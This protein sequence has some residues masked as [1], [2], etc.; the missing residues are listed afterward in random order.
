MPIVQNTMRHLNGIAREAA[1]Q[2]EE[3][4][5]TEEQRRDE[6]PRARDPREAAA[7]AVIAAESRAC[8]CGAAAQSALILPAS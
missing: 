4:G 1:A 3:R 7:Q 6:E 2:I 8:R 5:R